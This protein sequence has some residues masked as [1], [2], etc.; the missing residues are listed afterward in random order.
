MREAS[1]DASQNKNLKEEV[2][3]E[4]NPIEELELKIIT[5][6]SEKDKKKKRANELPEIYSLRVSFSSVLEVGSSFLE[7]SPPPKLKLP[8]VIPEH[9][10]LE[11]NDILPI[12]I[13]SNSTPNSKTQFMSS[14]EEQIGE[15]LNKQRSINGFVNYLPKI[16]NEDVKYFLKIDNK[17]L[18]FIIDHL[19]K[20]GNQIGRA[21]V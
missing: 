20:I 4:T 6:L 10:C 14:L 5:N 12:P 2:S 7:S 3:T 8:L 13:A 17:I 15:I 18:K 9:I 1:T 16:K 21:H 19:S 11:S